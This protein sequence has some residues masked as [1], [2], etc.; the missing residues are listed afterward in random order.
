[1][2]CK[3]CENPLTLDQQWRKR[4]FCSRK[5]NNLFRRKEWIEKLKRGGITYSYTNG[6]IRSWLLEIREHRCES[7]KLT[8]WLGQ[9]INLTMNH[10]DGDACNNRPEN[11]QLL[12]WN[13]HSMTETF[14]NKNKRRGTRHY[15]K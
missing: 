12:C 1:M 3:Q 5:C 8:E 4:K 2:N 9:P 6:L 15:R 11:L 13:C 10:I 7:C 14:G